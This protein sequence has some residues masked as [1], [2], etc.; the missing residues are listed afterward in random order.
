[1][2]ADWSAVWASFRVGG[3]GA[4]GALALG[5]WLAWELSAREFRGAGFVAA[6]AGLPSSIPLVVGTYLALD[7]A[8]HPAAFTWK[9][10]ALAAVFSELPEVLRASRA[11]MEALP[12]EYAHAARSLGSS[13]RRVFWLVVAPLAWRPIVAAAARAFGPAAVEYVFAIFFAAPHAAR[14]ALLR[15][16]LL[17]VM[18]VAALAAQAAAHRLSRA[19]AAT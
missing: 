17:P 15:G 19:G 1:M 4:L 5:V 6:L 7:L 18:V 9:V 2:T 10:A 8:G 16:P 11:A 3:I 12:R 13:G 14:D